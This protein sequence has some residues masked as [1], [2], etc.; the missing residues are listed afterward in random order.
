MKFLMIL[1]A[2]C[3]YASAGAQDY[4]IEQN[5]VKIQP[6]ISFKTGTAE[7]EPESK[8][9]LQIIKKYLDDK[10]AITLLRVEAHLDASAK[11]EAAQALTEKRAAAVCQALIGLGVACSRLL[12]VGFGSTKPVAGN[13]SLEGRSQNRRISFVN[14]SMRNIPIGGM[15][16]DGGGRV[17]ENPCY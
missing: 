1:L 10:P 14:A 2:T 15:P 3:L 4:R 17:A 16:V 6:V 5:E 7:L 9:A 13:D 12:P 8:A 11:P